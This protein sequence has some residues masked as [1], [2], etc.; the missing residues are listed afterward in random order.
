VV[1]A[2]KGFRRRTRS[3]LR[4]RVRERGIPPVT[5]GLQRFAVGDLASIHIDPSIPKG[6]PH[7]RFQGR[8]GR[9]IGSQGKAYLI[10]VREGGKAKAVLARPEHLRRSSP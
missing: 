7:V 6:Q 2:S 3:V 4:N 10:E 5:P 1:K 9:V 8:T